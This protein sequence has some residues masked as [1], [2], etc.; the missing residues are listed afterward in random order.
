MDRC[1][2]TTPAHGE[3]VD[4]QIRDGLRQR[5]GQCAKKAEQGLLAGGDSHASAQ[6]GSGTSAQKQGIVSE[7]GGEG[8]RAAC[9]SARQIRNL[10]GARHR[11]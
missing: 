1:V 3:L 6:I 5:D 4:A 7:L 11:W 9:V 2:G 10:L 8:N